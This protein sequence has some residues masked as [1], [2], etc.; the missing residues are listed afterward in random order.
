VYEFTTRVLGKLPGIQHVNM[1][2]E[3]LTLKRAYLR[4][5]RP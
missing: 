2:S 5:D 1:A 3:L 4:V